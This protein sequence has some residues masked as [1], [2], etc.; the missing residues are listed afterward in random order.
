MFS[1][2]RYGPFWPCPLLGRSRARVLD[3]PSRNFLA[4]FEDS[5][6][7]PHLFEHL[8]YPWALWAGVDHGDALTAGSAGPHPELHAR[9]SRRV[10]GR[11]R[12]RGRAVPA[13]PRG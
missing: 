1:L 2:V 12:W 3:I 11:A 7:A 10:H 5:P 4:D 13:Q 9:R 6:A 8:F